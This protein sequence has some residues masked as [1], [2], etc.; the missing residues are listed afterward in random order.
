MERKAE[1]KLYAV[2]LAGYGILRFFVEFLRD[3]PKGL[4][5]LGDGQWLAILAV[6]IC[7]FVF[8]K[9]N[10]AEQAARNKC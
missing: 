8:R 10:T 7:L 1:G 9:K 4:L 3:T 6:L 2:F 5:G